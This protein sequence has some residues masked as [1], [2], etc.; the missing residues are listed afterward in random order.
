MG[1]K[2]SARDRECAESGYHMLW[3]SLLIV[4]GRVIFNRKEY[5]ILEE[6]SIGPIGV[7]SVCQAEERGQ[8]TQ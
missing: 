3:V 6:L 5:T 4:R 8:I 2:I 7:L 1:K